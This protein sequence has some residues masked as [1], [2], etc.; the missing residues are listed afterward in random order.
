MKK[1]CFDLIMCL[2]SALSFAV[3]FWALQDL[4]LPLTHYR[5]EMTS[6]SSH[7]GNFL[8]EVT[9]HIHLALLN[10]SASLPSVF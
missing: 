1:S 7:T 4:E 8:L 10:Y 5:N 9:G 2:S 3:C 6:A